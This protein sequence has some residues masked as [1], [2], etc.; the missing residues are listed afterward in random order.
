MKQRPVVKGFDGVVGAVQRA[1]A[2]VVFQIAAV[3]EVAVGESFAGARTGLQYFALEKRPLGGR[4][5]G[6]D[7]NGGF[8][9][10]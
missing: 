5:C 7:D 10:E 3:V 6:V 9:R 2:D 1:P 8:G 4:H